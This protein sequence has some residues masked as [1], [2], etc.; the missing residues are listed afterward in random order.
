MR[1]VNGSAYGLAVTTIG[2]DSV[3]GRSFGFLASAPPLSS[4]A[5]GTYLGDTLVGSVGGGGSTTAKWVEEV[6]VLLKTSTILTGNPVA[7]VAFQMH[8][9]DG[10]VQVA[11]SGLTVSLRLTLGNASTATEC[12]APD[13]TSG[14]GLCSASVEENWFS[15]T[16][17]ATVEALVVAV[18]SS[19]TVAT[20]EALSMAL[21]LKP[22]YT[23]LS[24]AGM[25]IEFPKYPL[26]RGDEFTVDINANTNGQALDVWLLKVTMTRVCSRYQ[27]LRR[28]LCS[29]LLL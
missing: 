19:T 18:Y 20:S 13:S 9:E 15:S 4:F 22:V 2:D 29:E 3:I 26:A 16:S 28:A 1:L 6:D 12:S 21:Q 25:V 14:I 24:S 7:E 10:R 8:D 27:A 11:T 23:D 5:F 17:V